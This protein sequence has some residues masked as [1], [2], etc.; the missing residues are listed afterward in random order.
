MPEKTHQER[1][2]RVRERND[3]LFKKSPNSPL[4]H[5]QKEDFKGL[6]Y[7]PID[8]K[9][10]LFFEMKKFDYNS[11][12]SIRTT[13]GNI[14]RYTRYGYFEFEIDGQT[15]TL[16]VFKPIED[17]YLFLPFKDSTTGKETYKNGRYVEIEKISKNEWLVDFNTAYNPLCAYNDNWDC[18]FTPDENILKIPIKAGMKF[19]PDYRGSH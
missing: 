11:E 6:E 7:F 13:G 1:I 9:Y 3:I 14:R 8:Q 10:E 2:E 16:T 4:T 19:Y 15:N 12:I 17:D 5:H 18:S